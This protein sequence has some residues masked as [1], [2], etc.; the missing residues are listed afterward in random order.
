MPLRRQFR[1]AREEEEREEKKEGIGFVSL[2]SSSGDSG[3]PFTLASRV[4][5]ANE[6]GSKA[7]P[8]K[9]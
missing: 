2:S 5:G 9:K 3:R 6:P 1:A 7:L 4:N 8:D